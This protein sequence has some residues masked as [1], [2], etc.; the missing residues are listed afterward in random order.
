M[1][2]LLKFLDPCDMALSCL[3]CVKKGF[4]YAEVA[5]NGSEC[6]FKD[7]AALT[8]P[9]TFVTNNSQDCG[10]DDDGIRAITYGKQIFTKL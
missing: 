1:K 5:V 8:E 7:F 3:G 2:I 6:C 4:V 9:V 10:P